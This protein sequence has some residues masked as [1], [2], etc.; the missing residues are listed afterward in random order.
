MIDENERITTMIVK[1][2]TITVDR[3]NETI[4]HS[5]NETVIRHLKKLNNNCNRAWTRL[6]VVSPG[7]IG[8]NNNN[9]YSEKLCNNLF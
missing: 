6:Q 4:G 5:K 2:K 1:W 8:E 9:N 3:K 7:K